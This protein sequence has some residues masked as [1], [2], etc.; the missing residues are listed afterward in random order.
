MRYW[1]Q[2][3]AE[4]NQRIASRTQRVHSVAARQHAPR[5]LQEQQAHDAHEEVRYRPPIL[6]VRV[7]TIYVSSSY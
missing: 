6:L 7:P 5:A 1:L 4:A 2:E 3:R